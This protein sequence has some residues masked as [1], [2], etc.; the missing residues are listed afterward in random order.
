MEGTVYVSFVVDSL[1]K[2]RNPKLLRGVG[3]ELDKEALRVVNLMPIW[4]PGKINGNPVNVQ[5][6]IPIRFTLR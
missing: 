2:V 5:Y 6:N 1:G 4:T 3:D